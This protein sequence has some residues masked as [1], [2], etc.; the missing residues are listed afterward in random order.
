MCLKSS[1][2]DNFVICQNGTLFFFPSYSRNGRKLSNNLLFI[3][4]SLIFTA[5]FIVHVNE[6]RSIIFESFADKDCWI[7]FSSEKQLVIL[8][9]I[10]IIINL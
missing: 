1:S 10:Y 7:S 8:L 6:D 9:L 4:R 5:E 3:K 2:T